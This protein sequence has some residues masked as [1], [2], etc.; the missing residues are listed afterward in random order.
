[1]CACF[2][3]SIIKKQ[4]T[5]KSLP[6]GHELLLNCKQ[7]CNSRRLA[8]NNFS[9][10]Y[11]N[12]SQDTLSELP[13]IQN[14]KYIKTNN[15]REDYFCLCEDDKAVKG[16]F[17]YRLP[18]YQGFQV[19]YS[20][21]EGCKRVNTNICGNLILVDTVSRHAKL[22]NVFFEGY[23]DQHSVSR[24]FTID[25]NYNITLFTHTCYE[26][27]CYISKM[28]SI[29]INPNQKIDVFRHHCLPQGNIYDTQSDNDQIPDVLVRS[30]SCEYYQKLYDNLQRRQR[31][32]YPE[33]NYLSLL[34]VE[35]TAKDS[36]AYWSKYLKIAKQR[37]LNDSIKYVNKI[38]SLQNVIHPVDSILPFGPKSLEYLIKNNQNKI[39][40][41]I[42]S[43]QYI[44]NEELKN[45]K[46]IHEA[47][48]YYLAFHP[49][50]FPIEEDR[51]LLKLNSRKYI[52]LYEDMEN[53]EEL[54]IGHIAVRISDMQG[55]EVY[56][57]TTGIASYDND[58]DVQ[59]HTIEKDCCSSKSCESKGYLIFYERK[60]QH[61]II[62]PVYELSD[63]NYFNFFYISKDKIIYIFEGYNKYNN[64]YQTFILSKSHEIKITQDKEF[65]INKIVANN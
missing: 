36:V 54:D 11:C 35:L 40:F 20:T 27:G 18:D 45:R 39:G 29:K 47:W 10:Y 52:H 38:D 44:S 62:I 2:S 64:Y 13:V 41:L 59:F 15:D 16:N 8:D 19:Y 65:I 57:S 12:L 14:I 23:G 48:M 60:K 22:I 53:E 24:Y 6:M 31:F 56:Y 43:N 9:S 28:Y 4:E 30:D 34:E 26:E 63:G 17:N 1:V 55:F 3:Q 7:N 61:G 37:Y 33:S 46:L 25:K 42:S 50:V 58:C 49:Q 5:Y 21:N 51:I 32:P